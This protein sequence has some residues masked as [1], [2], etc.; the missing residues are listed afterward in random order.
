MIQSYLLCATTYLQGPLEK[1]PASQHKTSRI[2]LWA[3][4]V[5]GLL[6]VRRHRASSSFS[7]KSGNCSM[8]QRWTLKSTEQRQSSLKL[9]A[10]IRTVK[11]KSSDWWLLTLNF[12]VQQH[13]AF[14]SS[15]ALPFFGNRGL[16]EPPDCDWNFLQQV[17]ASQVFCFLRG[18]WCLCFHCRHF[19]LHTH[20]HIKK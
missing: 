2:R 15:A 11:T 17:T 19:L 16:F 6:S 20:T 7:W 10:V 18:W 12:A 3:C 4:S 5:A 13:P 14:C 1:T 8:A 9:T